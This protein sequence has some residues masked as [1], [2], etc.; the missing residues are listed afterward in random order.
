MSYIILHIIYWRNLVV[1]LDGFTA[2]I[3]CLGFRFHLQHLWTR[4]DYIKNE[5]Y[6]IEA[7]S[8]NNGL[9]KKGISLS[10]MI[11]RKIQITAQRY[12]ICLGSLGV[13]FIILEIYKFIIVQISNS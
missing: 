10:R 8:D 4:M 6:K 5:D 12:K 9:G 2:Y 1:L 13:E 11:Q 3:P 7:M